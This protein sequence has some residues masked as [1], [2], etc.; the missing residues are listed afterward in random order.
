L[1][2]IR[3]PDIYDKLGSDV[4]FDV[5]IVTTNR[6]NRKGGLGTDLL[7]RSVELARVL[8]FKGVKTEAT[9]A[10]SRRAF[11]KIGF[12][13]EAEEVYADFVGLD[14]SKPF[15]GDM[16]PHLVCTLLTRDLTKP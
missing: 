7:K 4:L 8:G 12:Q 16:S 9:G 2:F 10:F 11:E 13:V 5:K 15:K 14:G 1:F 6:F 3:A